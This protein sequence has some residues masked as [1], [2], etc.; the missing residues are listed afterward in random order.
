MTWEPEDNLYALLGILIP[1][2]P[3][4]AIR[5]EVTAFLEYRKTPGNDLTRPEAT[6]TVKAKVKGASRR[7]THSAVRHRRNVHPNLETANV[8][9]NAKE[10]GFKPPTGSWEDEIVEIEASDGP[11]GSIV[12]YLTWKGG[13]KTS[14]SHD[15]VYKRCPQKVERS[16]ESCEVTS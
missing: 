2:Y 9:A 6:G 13:Q 12:V 15:Q 1:T 16:K 7:A 8:T 4:L 11:A 5:K 10:A 14:H 3:D